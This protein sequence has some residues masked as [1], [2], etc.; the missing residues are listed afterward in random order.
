MSIDVVDRHGYF[1]E[2][3][4]IGMR[5]IY[6][7]TVTEADIAMFAGASGDTNPMH[8]D[9]EFAKKTRFKG[10]IAHGM[11]TASLISTIFGTKMPG[12]GSIYLSQNLRF[13]AP[14]R[15][16]D[17]VVARVEIG[18]IDEDKGRVDFVC[19]CT[20]GDRVVLTGDA[21]IMVPRRADVKKPRAA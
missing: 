5:S 16:G 14:V 8:L 2:D 11:L 3:L 6:S 1:L 7:R 21:A 20:V 10:R 17:T 9:E 15:I 13:T 12:P 4:S 19:T 18:A